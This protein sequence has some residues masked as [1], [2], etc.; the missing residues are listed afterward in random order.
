M[1][2]MR[3]LLI[4]RLRPLSHPLTSPGRN[5]RPY[6]HR[7]HRTP[8]AFSSVL[9]SR[10]YATNPETDQSPRAYTFA[11]IK[12]LSSSPPPS[13]SSSATSASNPKRI[14]I[15]V[16]EP[17][18]LAATGQIPGAY[19]MP[20][21]TNPDAFHLST[22]DFFDRFGF[23]KPG[24][25]DDLPASGDGRGEGGVE[26]IFYCKAGVR[27]RAAARLAREWKGV[28]VG[29]FQGGWLDWEGNGGEREFK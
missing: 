14:L 28:K 19:S 5:F 15:D 27:S 13:P 21:T 2:P 11:E 9:Q 3:P 18:E 17:S 4:L 7:V 6:L 24:T 12:S 20:L 29:D 22:E 25:R 10:T 8:Q 23:E 16:R 1:P 26:V